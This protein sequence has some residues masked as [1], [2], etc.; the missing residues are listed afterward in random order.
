[1]VDHVGRR[2]QIVEAARSL[3]EEQGV[4]KTTVKDVADSLGVARSLIYH[5]F[6]DKSELTSAVLDSY[7][8]D[9]IAALEDWN[10]SRCEGEIEDALDDV[11]LLLRMGVFENTSFRRA[12]DSQENAALF[13]EFSSI[14]AD[15]TARF[16]MENT[17]EDY[18]RLHDV[19]ID[20]LYETFYV[21]VLGICGYVR[22][23]KDTP[24]SLVKDLIVQTLHMDR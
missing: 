14:V 23:H 1:M 24:D 8:N 13:I 19:K 7:A 11:V 10:E 15:H 12:L 21:L 16:L 17:A 18:A 9:Y 6:S 20:H 2:E 4:S 22:T 3:Y 5:Y